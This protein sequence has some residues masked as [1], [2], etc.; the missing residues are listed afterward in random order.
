MPVKIPDTLPAMGILE[1]EN[2]FVMGENRAL[3]QDIRP[4]R[5]AILNLMPTKIATETQL[6]RLLGNTPL[7]VE[8]ELLHMESH[9]SKHTPAEHLLAALHVRSRRCATRSFDGL[10]ITGRAR[11]SSCPSKRSTTGRS[12]VELMDWARTQRLLDALHLLGRAGGAVPLLRRPEVRPAGEDVRGLRAQRERSATSGCCAAST[13]CSTRP[14]RAT[15]RSAART[16]WRCPSSCCSPSRR[17]RR[18]HRALRRPP[19][20]VRDRALRVRP[21]DAAGRVRARRQQGPADRRA[22]ATTIP[23]TTPTREPIVRW[24]GH[25]N[26]LFANWLNYYVYQQTPYDLGRLPEGGAGR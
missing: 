21:A 5:L 12:C 16:C 18:L 4:L 7:Q 24:R 9:E 14:T 26:L 20:R 2:I 13:T 25:A 3:H 22:A 1:S 17:G 19:P 11:S 23:A 6:L 10:I 15:P 8:I